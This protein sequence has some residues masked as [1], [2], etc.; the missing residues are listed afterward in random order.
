MAVSASRYI[1]DER[2]LSSDGERGSAGVDGGSVL[3]RVDV[4]ASGAALMPLVD[5]RVR[6]SRRK[7]EK[8]KRAV[9]SHII[10]RSKSA[11]GA[12]K[13]RRVRGNLRRR[14]TARVVEPSKFALATDV[15]QHAEPAV[16]G[17]QSYAQEVL[18]QTR[19][20]PVDFSA[21][22]SKVAGHPMECD[23]PEGPLTIEAIL[24]AAIPDLE[25]DHDILA[26][27]A[28]ELNPSLADYSRMATTRQ[29]QR[30]VKDCE[31]DE[32]PKTDD[33]TAHPKTDDEMSE[34]SQCVSSAVAGTA[35][36]SSFCTDAGKAYSLKISTITAIFDLVVPAVLDLALI[37]R[38]S[39]MTGIVYDPHSRACGLGRGSGFPNAAE[40]RLRVGNGRFVSL[41]V[42]GNGRVKL[43]GASTL[44]ECFAVAKKLVRAIQHCVPCHG[45]ENMQTVL[46]KYEL[47]LRSAVNLSDL[48]DQLSQDGECE[49]VY[50]PKRYNALQ[51]VP[52]NGT[53]VCL[54][55]SGKAFTTSG[56]CAD[57]GALISA[58][59]L[60]QKVEGLESRI[61][62]L[63]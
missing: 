36:S 29:W 23:A 37:A 9:K 42:F 48:Y 11:G 44:A 32:Y 24:G 51:V 21:A 55:S 6:S 56:S 50:E 7:A 61:D 2:L 62:M 28:G 12:M 54:F 25:S 52:P 31:G 13:K 53:K 8:K 59:W 19:E 3:P 45:Y 40:V 49:V 63:A 17:S 41:L 57:E 20:T 34:P 60:K 43:S 1:E 30:R 16:N 33:E 4:G 35:A 15:Y 38:D 10:E 46:V 58:K 39:T 26:E 18:L 47:D 22:G 27:L 14:G 5:G